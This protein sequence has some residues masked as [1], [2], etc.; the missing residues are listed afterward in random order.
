MKTSAKSIATLLVLFS[1]FS[2]MRCSTETRS[3]KIHTITLRVDTENIDNSDLEK[4]C[5]FKGQPT[6]VPNSD[7]TIDVKPGD[8]ILWVGEST[9]PGDHEVLIE[10]INY[11]GGHG[12]KNLL[13]QNV[14][15]GS[16]GVLAAR[17]LKSAQVGEFEKYIIKFKVKNGQPGNGN[18]QIDPK[19]RIH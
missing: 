6:G 9:S 5:S 11:R 1:V 13:G 7:F 18:F 2:F 10:S 8:I 3:F 19:L 4:Y 15:Q 14:I 12:S 17:V 16:N